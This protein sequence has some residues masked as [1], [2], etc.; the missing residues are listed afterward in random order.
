MRSAWR[1]QR[2]PDV[3]FVTGPREPS[4]RDPG[5]PK[6]TLRPEPADVKASPS[7]RM[8][9]RI[10]QGCC[11]AL[12]VITV[13]ASGVLPAC[14]GMCCP[15][16][17]DE[18]AVHAQMPCCAEPTFSP[19]DALRLLPATFA[20]LSSS[21]QT[22]VP[23]AVVERPGTFEVSPPRVQATLTIASRAHHEPTPPLFLL[24]AQFLI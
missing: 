18:A 17:E 3:R 20:G 22:W 23:V 10:L 2:S 7:S 13:L 1:R 5:R 4:H 14:G 6:T 16:A 9:R 21:P 15:V 24:N 12:A 8:P 19:S 11:L